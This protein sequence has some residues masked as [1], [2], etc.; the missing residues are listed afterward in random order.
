MNISEQLDT[1]KEGVKTYW[2]IFDTKA[3]D[4]ACKVLDEAWETYKEAEKA[5]EETPE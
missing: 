5:A 1:Y 2:A 3:A 4:E